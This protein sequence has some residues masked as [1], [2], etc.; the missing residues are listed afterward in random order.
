MFNIR[1]YNKI[2]D[3]GL[4]CFP[5]ESYHVADDV[6]LPDAILLRSQ[7][8]HDETLPDSVIAVARA[9]AGT[10]NVPVDEYTQRG[11][12]VF[13]SPGANANAVKELVV[14]GMLLSSR[15]IV[16]GR[17]FV[18]TL[19]QMDDSEE[20]A[21]LLEKEKKRFAGREIRGR[22][23]GIVGLGAIGSLVADVALALGMDVVG[24]D[25]ALSID[26]AWKL[27]SRVRRMESLE[28]LL[29]EV[30]FLTL[31]V[32]AI[33]A[34]KHMINEQTLSLMKSTA[35]VLNF[36]RATIVDPEAI[37]AALDAGSIGQYI[38]DFPEPCL[39]GHDKVISV[40]H[41]GASTAEAEE[42]CA[43]MAVD[44][45]CDYLENG[46]IRNSVNLPHTTMPRSKGAC[47]M[48]FINNNTAGVLG[49][50][51]SI[52][53]ENELNVID[54]VNKSRNNVA[55]NILDLENH[56]NSD[57]IKKIQSVEHIFNLRIL[58]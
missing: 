39:I 52:F 35:V 20:M 40:P 49:D 3:K 2:S 15:G 6:E 13:N 50:L 30:D 32:P 7:K 43:V 38:C 12:V 9:G 10:N 44:Q 53:A 25:P 37:V 17:D 26:A 23:I 47:R 27:S 28:A 41:I 33:P 29:G 46:N 1:T 54:M 11:I 56:P 8:L 42:N 18:N 21:K 34:T 58:D 48:T 24:Y 22:T 5:S 55:Y 51:L 57:V 45:V 31:H 19:G 36:A 16:Q 14:T 4:S